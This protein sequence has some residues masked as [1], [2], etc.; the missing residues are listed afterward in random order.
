MENCEAMT[1]HHQITHLNIHI[2]CSLFVIQFTSK[3]H[4]FVHFF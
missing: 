3:F 4:C 1:S 2:D